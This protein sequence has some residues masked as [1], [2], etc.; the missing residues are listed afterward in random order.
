M[1]HSRRLRS[2]APDDKER[3]ARQHEHLA[4]EL[5]G[6][7][8][9]GQVQFLDEGT[10]GGQSEQPNVEQQRI[11]VVVERVFSI[12]NRYY[13]SRTKKSHGR[14]GAT[15]FVSYSFVKS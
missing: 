13:D 1:L 15:T 11:V 3:K 14:I 8:R 12:R 5:G 10:F 4:A 2:M 9:R 7:H 6:L